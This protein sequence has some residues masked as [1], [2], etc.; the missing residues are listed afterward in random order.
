[1]TPLGFWH[2]GTTKS[3][4]WLRFIDDSFILFTLGVVSLVSS[5][6]LYMYDSELKDRLM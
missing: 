4:I 6:A 5:A 3:I 2:F 1:M